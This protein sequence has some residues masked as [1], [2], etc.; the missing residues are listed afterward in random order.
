MEGGE[1]SDPLQVCFHV[2]VLFV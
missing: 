1:G 2:I